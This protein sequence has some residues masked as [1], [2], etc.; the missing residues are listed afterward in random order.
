LSFQA[1]EID[2]LR[3]AAESELLT[4]LA[5]RDDLIRESRSRA[6]QAE[7]ALAAATARLSELS[8]ESARPS[9]LTGAVGKV[10][11]VSM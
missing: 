2:A 9:G 1:R 8:D 3:F 7:A 4:A 10:R 11:L 6:D 5:S